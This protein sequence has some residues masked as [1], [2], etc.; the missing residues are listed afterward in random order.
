MK[1]QE[2]NLVKEY[3]LGKLFESNGFLIPVITGSTIEMGEQYGALMIEEMQKAY[4]VLIAPLVKAGELT[5]KDIQFWKN[6]AYGT[7]SLRTK[8]FYEGV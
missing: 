4:D 2:L 8:Q 3:S 5:E 7:G 1:N 6:R